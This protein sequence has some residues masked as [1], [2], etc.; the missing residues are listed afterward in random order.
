VGRV[1]VGDALGVAG[2]GGVWRSRDAVH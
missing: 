1:R 2:G